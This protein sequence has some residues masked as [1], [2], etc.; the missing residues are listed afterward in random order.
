MRGERKDLAVPFRAGKQILH[1][2]Q[3]DTFL[4]G[5]RF[6]EGIAA[7]VLGSDR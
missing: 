1:F 3:D 2:V 7:T 5:Y 4:G 6:S